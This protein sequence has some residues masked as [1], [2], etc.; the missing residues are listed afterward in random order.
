MQAYLGISNPCAG[1]VFD[2]T[3]QNM[4]GHIAIPSAIRVGVECE[5]AVQLADN[6]T[7]AMAPFDRARVAG[8]IGG[9]M[10]AIEI[11]EDRYLDYPALDT[12]TLIADDFFGAGCVLGAIATR[13]DPVDLA[14]TTARMAINGQEVGSGA[15][16]DVL[17]HPLD[18]LVWLAT[19]A[20]A[21]GAS[22]QAGEFV[23]LGSLVQT[24]WVAAGDE[25]RIVNDPLGE[26]RAIFT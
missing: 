5:I 16:T 15:G 6:L 25:V 4:Q 26:V 21:R 14:H 11:V 22:L 12:P 19:N 20:A 3:V 9:C 10:A 17:G 8:A 2:A 13:F 24:H 23:L 1:G 7:P 18:A